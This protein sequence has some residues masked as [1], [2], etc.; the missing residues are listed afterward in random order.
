VRF[1]NT[2]D[3]LDIVVVFALASVTA[4]GSHPVP[5]EVLPA[6]IRQYG[7][8][9]VRPIDRRSSMARRRPGFDRGQFFKIMPNQFG[10]P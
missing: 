8:P 3:L 9:S 2:R 1:W 10:R 5:A 6:W 4:P 7:V